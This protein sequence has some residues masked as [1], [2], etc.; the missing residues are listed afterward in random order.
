MRFWEIQCRLIHFFDLPTPV[1]LA[2]VHMFL[3]PSWFAIISTTPWY[4]AAAAAACLAF[5]T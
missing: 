5:V 3:S 1:P 2:C 4:T